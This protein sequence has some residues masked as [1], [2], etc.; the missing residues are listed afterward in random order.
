MLPHFEPGVP[1]ELLQATDCLKGTLAPQACHE[2][3]HGLH[4]FFSFP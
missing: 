4:L 2:I 3:L 1:S